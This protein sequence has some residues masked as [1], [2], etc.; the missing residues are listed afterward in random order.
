[1]HELTQQSW[2]RM[3]VCEE[4]AVALR[5]SLYNISPAKPPHPGENVSALSSLYR[6]HFY[7]G[8]SEVTWGYF[9]TRKRSGANKSLLKAF[10][11]NAFITLTRIHTHIQRHRD[12]QHVLIYATPRLSI[13]NV[14]LCR[15]N[16]SSQHQTCICFSRWAVKTKGLSY[17][18]KVYS[19]G[20][21]C[22]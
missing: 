9:L 2:C 10:W 21:N 4:V 3:Q 18:F 16:K 17:T 14:K 8:S 20:L 22:Q 6:S 15:Q 5:L 1:M 12:T 13:S 19:H 7:W 11:A